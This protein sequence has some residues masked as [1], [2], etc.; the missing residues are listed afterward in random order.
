MNDIL[1]V[2]ECIYRPQTKFAKVTFSQECVCPQGGVY[3][4]M[5]W[6]RHNSFKG[7]YFD[8]LRKDALL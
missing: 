2:C 8:N 7:K 3:P 6:G 5:Q 4:R 1:S